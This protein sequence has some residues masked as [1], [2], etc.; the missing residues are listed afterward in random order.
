M[1]KCLDTGL[2]SVPLP[3]GLLLRSSVAGG[4]KPAEQCNRSSLGRILQGMP[5]AGRNFPVAVQAF[6]CTASCRTGA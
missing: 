3:R 4:G 1:S 2:V 6:A 5:V